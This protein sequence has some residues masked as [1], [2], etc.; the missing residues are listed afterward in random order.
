MNEILR[1]HWIAA[2]AEF[3]T[4]KRRFDE[5]TKRRSDVAIEMEVFRLT[6]EAEVNRAVA[7]KRQRE[8]DYVAAQREVK[9]L[10]DSAETVF[11]KAQRE[12]KRLETLMKRDSEAES[13]RRQRQAQ[14][15]SEGAV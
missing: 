1:A 2:Q 4:A 6:H 7:V 9:S 3:E 5:V 13:I 11:N 12:M 10:L 8:S 14:Q 15:E